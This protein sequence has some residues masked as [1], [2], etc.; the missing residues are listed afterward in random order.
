MK[1]IFQEKF[2]TQLLHLFSPG[3]EVASM[4]F[5]CGISDPARGT[6]GRGSG[7]FKG[8]S[9]VRLFICDTAQGIKDVVAFITINQAPLRGCVCKARFSSDTDWVDGVLAC[10]VTDR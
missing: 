5:L 9:D 2:W 6:H 3:I 1:I 4:D 10:C 7:E 8:I